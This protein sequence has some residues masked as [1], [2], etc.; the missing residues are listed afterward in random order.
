MSWSENQARRSR[1]LAA[2]SSGEQA[3]AYTRAR[4]ALLDDPDLTV[5]NQLIVLDEFG[6]FIAQHLLRGMLDY[7]REWTGTRQGVR[8]LL[9]LPLGRD[10]AQMAQDSI[11]DQAKRYEALAEHVDQHGY[12]TRTI[13]R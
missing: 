12:A 6:A 7:L 2:F 9:I 4:L 8:V 5:K 1:P 13:V 10:Y 11:G 3:F